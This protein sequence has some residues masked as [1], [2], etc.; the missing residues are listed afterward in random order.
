MFYLRCQKKGR[1]GRVA[2]RSRHTAVFATKMEGYCS[3]WL[4][5]DWRCLV[6]AAAYAMQHVL[7]RRYLLGHGIPGQLGFDSR[8]ISLFLRV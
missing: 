3:V 6:F 2:G 1:S 8:L 7:T 5:E 4:D